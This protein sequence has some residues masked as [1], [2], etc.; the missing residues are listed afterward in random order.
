T[1]VTA[2]GDEVGVVTDVLHQPSS[3]LLLVDAGGKELLIPLVAGIVTSVD[4]GRTITI[5]P[6]V[7]LLD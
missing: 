4:R 1:V 2:A 5:D 7:G 6:P 3:E